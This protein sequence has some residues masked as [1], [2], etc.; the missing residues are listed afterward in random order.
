MNEDEKTTVI[1]LYEIQHDYLGIYLNT[2][3]NRE[4]VAYALAKDT[5]DTHEKWS[6][7]D[8]SVVILANGNE[9]VLSWK[10]YDG[11]KDKLR[12]LVEEV[13][14]DDGILMIEEE[15]QLTFRVIGNFTELPESWLDTED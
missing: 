12:E 1:A 15:W 4:N 7:D 3:N 14:D 5:Y 8:P 6:P 2:S 10:D 9:H 13:Y 11:L